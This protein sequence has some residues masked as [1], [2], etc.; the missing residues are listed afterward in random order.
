[1]KSLNEE[2]SGFFLS[3]LPE[4]LVLIYKENENIRT[5]SLINGSYLYETNQVKAVIDPLNFALQ[6]VKFLTP[7]VKEFHF[8]FAA[9]MSI[10]MRGVMQVKLFDRCK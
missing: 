6:D 5:L 8:E 2:G 10:V 3:R 1:V 9:E 7:C 4:K